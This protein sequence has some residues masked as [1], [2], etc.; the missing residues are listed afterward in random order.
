MI[1]RYESEFYIMKKYLV[2]YINKVLEV[3]KIKFID[4]VLDKDKKIS[5]DLTKHFILPLNKK[6]QSIIQRIKENLSPDK[7]SQV[8]TILNYKIDALDYDVNS[9]NNLGTIF[10]LVKN[11]M[12]NISIFLMENYGEILLN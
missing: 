6:F 11:E 1:S 2:V 5:F 9:Y 12:K 7:I 4:F 8:D 3:L 10:S